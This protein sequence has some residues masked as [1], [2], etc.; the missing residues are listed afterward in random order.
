MEVH[1]HP[2][3][4][5]KNFKE[6]FLE[7]LMIFLAVTL[8]FFAEN[9]RE[10]ITDKKNERKTIEE[11]KTDLAAD[12]IRLRNLIDS[13]VLNYHSWVDSLHHD[14]D[15]LPLH[16]NEKR[17]SKAL[18][19]TT[20]WDVYTPPEIVTANLKNS[21]TFNLIEDD[22]VKKEFLH[23]NIAINDYSKY[24]DFLSQLQHSLDTS[25]SSLID[26]VSA[27]KFLDKL[28]KR[29]DFLDDNDIPDN[30]K[31]KT[32]YK[33]DFNKFL[34]KIDQVDFKIH[35]VHFFEMDILNEDLKLLNIL[36]D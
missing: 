27:R 11:F 3:V 9:L 30:I 21:S 20:Y 13:Y 23:Y 19:N 28:D 8:G 31:F 33:A 7:F 16:G 14:I 26:R 15:S 2:K 24:S 34:N 12:T 5:K 32:Y 17:I 29:R 22:N 36:K 10:H 1:H 4:E 35:D 6:Y 18:F 25:F